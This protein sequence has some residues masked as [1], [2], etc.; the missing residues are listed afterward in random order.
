MFRS[1]QLLR[2]GGFHLVS[3]W[4]SLI[5]LGA[6]LAI[7]LIAIPLN[8]RLPE[9]TPEAAAAY[10]L[11]LF[12][13]FFSIETIAL[14]IL[15]VVHVLGRRAEKLLI[16]DLIRSLVLILFVVYLVYQRRMLLPEFQGAMLSGQPVAE[17]HEKLRQWEVFKVILLM[18]SALVGQ[19]SYKRLRSS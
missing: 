17:L 1:F 12:T 10:G 2:W 9:H 16:L 6:N 11:A 14:Q 13:R 19:F 8:F 15:V 7:D 5:L 3:V 4:L 18:L